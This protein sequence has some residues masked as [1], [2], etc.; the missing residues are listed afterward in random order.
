MKSVHKKSAGLHHTLLRS[1]PTLNHLWE[2]LRH[3]AQASLMID[4]AL[5]LSEVA[6]QAANEQIKMYMLFPLEGMHAAKVVNI[7]ETPKKWEEKCK[8][9]FCEAHIVQHGG[10]A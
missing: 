3:I 7:S 2:N 5:S 8:K 4:F 1:G 6:I 10:E 9:A